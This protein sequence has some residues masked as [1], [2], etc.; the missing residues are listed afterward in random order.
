M[1]V[2]LDKLSDRPLHATCLESFLLGNI[3]NPI[4]QNDI[5][6]QFHPLK[7][8]KKLVKNSVE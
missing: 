3:F 6:K 5:F 1:V 2:N 7:E 4:S 8:V